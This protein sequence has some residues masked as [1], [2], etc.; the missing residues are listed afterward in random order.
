MKEGDKVYCHKNDY[1][2]F[3]H[4]LFI[5]DNYY[6]V[7]TITKNVIYIKEHENDQFG[8]SFEIE[9]F[10]EYFCTLKEHRK[11]KLKKLNN[12]GL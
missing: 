12:D 7:S 6:T 1:H 2:M 10:E 3:D 4:P 11:Q 5:K 8:V 9:D